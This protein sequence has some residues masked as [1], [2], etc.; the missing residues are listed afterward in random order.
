VYEHVPVEV[1]LAGS[2]GKSIVMDIAD[3]ADAEI[4]EILVALG[5]SQL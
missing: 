2:E 3:D 5:V 1:C 4:V